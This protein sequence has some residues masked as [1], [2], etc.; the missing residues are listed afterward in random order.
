MSELACCRAGPSTVPA[1]RAFTVGRAHADAT[2][3][4]ACAIAMWIRCTPPEMRVRPTKPWVATRVRSAAMA[5]RLGLSRSASTL[6]RLSGILRRLRP[7][8]GREFAG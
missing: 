1:T 2:P 3:L 5:I 8:E 6:A 7:S 4:T